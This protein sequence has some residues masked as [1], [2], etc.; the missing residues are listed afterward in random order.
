MRYHYD[1]PPPHVKPGLANS[2]RFSNS[3]IFQRE[4]FENKCRRFFGPDV[5]PVTQPTVSKHCRKH[6]V[7][8]LTSGLWPGL[9]LFSSITGFLTEGGVL[10][11]C[12]AMRFNIL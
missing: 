7:L 6:G 1:K 12:Y 11:L 10:A 9:I 2:P 8:T 4:T 3:T 5:L